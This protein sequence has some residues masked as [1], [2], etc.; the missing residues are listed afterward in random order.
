[1]FYFVYV[2]GVLLCYGG[3]KS[4]MLETKPLFLNAL[5]DFLK[6]NL[7]GDSDATGSCEYEEI[8]RVQFCCNL[9]FF[10]RIVVEMHVLSGVKS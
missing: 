8:S 1:M 2:F 10:P 7:D 3:T 5:G 6:I 4:D 9:L